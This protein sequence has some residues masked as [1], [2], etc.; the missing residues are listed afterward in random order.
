MKK[1]VWGMLLLAGVLAAGCS[2]TGKKDGEEGAYGGGATG[3]AYGTL[4][5]S[6]EQLRESQNRT[7][8]FEY[9]QSDVPAQYH[10]L[11]RA[12]ARFLIDNSGTT[13]TIEG[14]AD[15]R[16][17]REYNIA[18]GEGRADAVRRFLQAEGVAGGQITTISY[19]E[20]RPAD[21][22]SNESAWS[23]N[24]RAVVRY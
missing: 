7:I 10:D 5:L 1:G 9:D 14:H 4:G 13:V 15:E 8:Y 3:G 2:S 17:S 23:L 16:G 20:E 11:L 12:H 19:G 18:L 21:P 22:G 6:A 24:R